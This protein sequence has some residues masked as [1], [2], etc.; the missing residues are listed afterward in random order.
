MYE[1]KAP[2]TLAEALDALQRFGA[3]ARVLAGGTDLMIAI[4]EH[5]L[6]PACVVDVKRIAGLA[7]VTLDPVGTLGLGA[8]VSVGDIERSI[9]VLARFPVLVSAASMLASGQVRN[10][11]TIGG[12]I[13]NASPAAD[14]APPLLVLE[15]IAT[16]VGTNGERKFPIAALF[17]GPGRTT[18]DGEILTAF[19]IKAMPARARATYLKH[20]PRNAMDIAIV[21]VAVLAVPDADG[22][23]WED[24]RIALGSVA[25]TPIRVPAA[26]AV[27]RG[28]PICLEAIEQAADI[29][30]REATPISD[31]R[32]SGDYR[33]AMVRAL[34]RRALEEVSL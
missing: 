9:P 12:N 28:A 8:L 6:R 29:A 5:G 20:G 34:T 7:E 25:P 21:G 4:R 31:L 19:T 13:C 33:R 23:S 30:A 14:L 26:E 17:S 10:L 11:A 2:T 3:E 22:R 24:V 16:A 32:A 15:A 1:Y 27:L 18:L